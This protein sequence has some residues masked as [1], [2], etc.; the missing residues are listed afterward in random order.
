[1][2]DW[3]SV[4]SYILNNG[5][6]LD[7]ILLAFY[8]IA[9][10]LSFDKVFLKSYNILRKKEP[11]VLYSAK[12]S[13]SSTLAFSFMFLIQALKYILY[14]FLPLATYNK[15]SL[16][17]LCISCTGLFNKLT[18]MFCMIYIWSALAYFI[19]Q[20]V[21]K[22]NGYLKN[23]YCILENIFSMLLIALAV[24]TI[25]ST[26]TFRF[27]YGADNYIEQTIM[28]TLIVF[29]IAGVI[30][31]AIICKTLH[32]NLNTNFCNEIK[33]LST[34]HDLNIRK[35]NFHILRIMT[36]NIEAIQ[37]YIITAL[38]IILSIYLPVIFYDSRVFSCLF[39]ALSGAID[40]FIIMQMSRTCVPAIT[41]TKLE[42]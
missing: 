23:K 20:L 15:Y 5:L 29:I 22:N 4:G 10:Y 16:G 2:I 32:N 35:N 42:E 21:L 33:A 28:N 6:I 41:Q 24:M 14:I 38:A 3:E 11:P 13:L 27:D 19:R 36:R 30:F 39:Y 26:S 18:L 34:K 17:I 9:F 7:I 31:L 8:F 12:F 40:L 1:M 25:S 37:V